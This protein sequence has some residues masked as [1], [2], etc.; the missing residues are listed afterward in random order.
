M[1][2]AEIFTRVRESLLYVVVYNKTFRSRSCEIK[3]TITDGMGDSVN[4]FTK[5]EVR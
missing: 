4:F 1:I 2:S 3:K 5:I